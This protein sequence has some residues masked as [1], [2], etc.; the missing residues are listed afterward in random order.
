M[1][2]NQSDSG[3]SLFLEVAFDTLDQVRQLADLANEQGKK[4]LS[5][6]LLQIMKEIARS[7]DDAERSEGPER[8]IVRVLDFQV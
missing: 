1:S 7:I 8:D 6:A 5:I 2:P 3:S 4:D